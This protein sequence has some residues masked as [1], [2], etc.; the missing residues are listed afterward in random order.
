M[1]RLY[2]GSNVVINKIDLSC[3]R[4]GKDFGCGFYLNPEKS[5]AM[6]MAV[7]TSRR[8]MEGVPV[9]NVYGFD[10]ALLESGSPL[11]VKVFRDYSIEW[12]EFVLMNRRNLGEQAAH[13]YDIVVGPIADD[14]V[15]LQMRR[16][17][18]G[19]ISIERMI[20]ELRFHKPSVQYFFGTEKAISYLK[21]IEDDGGCSVSDRKPLD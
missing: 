13:P 16:F 9:V 20:E 5:Q 15:G 8:M 21:K 19:Y 18:Q 14:T 10:E 17:M 2:H 4:K 6:E 7:R 1:L 12:A 3:S 11:A